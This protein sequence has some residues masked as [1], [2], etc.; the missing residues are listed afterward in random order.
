MGPGKQDTQP[1]Y[2]YET[3]PVE[4]LSYSL[5]TGTCNNKIIL[6]VPRDERYDAGAIP[7]ECQAHSQKRDNNTERLKNAVGRNGPLFTA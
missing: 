3:V 7:L 1:T 6:N 2:Q 5:E 4:Y